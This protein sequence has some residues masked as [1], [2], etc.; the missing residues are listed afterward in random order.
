MPLLWRARLYACRIG[1]FYRDELHIPSEHLQGIE[2]L[3]ALANRNVCVFGSMKQKKRSMDLVG[4]EQ[5]S[6]FG[7]QIR[8]V[9]RI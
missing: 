5:S 4:I 3:N 7:E 9:P 2:Q 6:L 8:I 1:S